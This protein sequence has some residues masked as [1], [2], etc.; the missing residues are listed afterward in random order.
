MRSRSLF[1]DSGPLLAVASTYWRA[2]F[3]RTLQGSGHWIRSIDTYR[4]VAILLLI[5]FTGDLY[6]TSPF[7]HGRRLFAGDPPVNARISGHNDPLP[8]LSARCTN[9][10][11]ASSSQLA[12]QQTV[13]P[14][15]SA[16]F[17]RGLSPRRGG[18]P[19]SYDVQSFCNVLRNGIDPAWIMLPPTMPRY[20][21]SDTQCVALWTYLTRATP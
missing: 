8:P 6:A 2:E 16:R 4:W 12:Q 14:V 20:D 7:E 17:L 5:C 11:R 9:C 3:N 13:G 21:V 10:H 1:P 15:L 19:S 18:P